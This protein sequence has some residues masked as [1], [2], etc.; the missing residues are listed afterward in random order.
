MLKN[1]GAVTQ[2]GE[3]THRTMSTTMLKRDLGMEA[4]CDN[5]GLVGVS[6]KW[7]YVTASSSHHDQIIPILSP[8][9]FMYVGHP[10]I[11]LFLKFEEFLIYLYM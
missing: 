8:L 10:Y 11:P 2:S 7:S 9:L 4:L 5:I 1:T 6:A 3:P